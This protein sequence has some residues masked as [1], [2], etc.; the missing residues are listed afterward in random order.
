MK[1]VPTGTLEHLTEKEA[2]VYEQL[3]TEMAGKMEGLPHLRTKWSMLR[4]LRARQFHLKKTKDMMDKYL[5]FRRKHPPETIAKMPMSSFQAMND[6]YASGYSGVDFEGNP[7]VVEEVAKS[8]PEAILANTSEDN[9]ID[10]LVQRFERMMYVVMPFLSRVHGRRIE[11]TCLVID[12]KH[13]KTSLFLNAKVR[14]FINICA[15]FG[16]DY[17][18]ETLGKCFIINAPFIFKTVWAVIKLALDERTVSKIFI[19]SGSGKTVLAKH[20]DLD[21]LPVSLGGKNQRKPG[22]LNGPW[23]AEMMDSFERKS[24]FM[25]DRTPEFQYYWLPAERDA[26]LASLEPVGVQPLPPVPI[27]APLAPKPSEQDYQTLPTADSRTPV[28]EKDSGS[29]KKAPE[30][31]HKGFNFVETVG[32]PVRTVRS[33]PQD[34]LIS[35]GT[36]GATSQKHH[37]ANIVREM[38]EAHFR[39]HLRTNVSVIKPRD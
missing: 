3:R 12:L 17:Y 6:Y 23:E 19:E 22:E 24:F 16:Q 10:F 7:I 15:K 38:P 39:V 18:P 4:F 1:H 32:S 2:H 21:Q 11:R 9:V 29:D 14:E 31:N 13:V 8:N 20:L 27:S 36:V 5:E 33:E 25:R 30:S 34:S 26:Y 28:P 37:S 35:W